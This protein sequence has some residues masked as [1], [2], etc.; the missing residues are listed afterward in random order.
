MASKTPDTVTER[1]LKRLF[2]ATVDNLTNCMKDGTATPKD[3]EVALKLIDQYQ[4]TIDLDTTKQTQ[5]TLDLPFDLE[6][7]QGIAQ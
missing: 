7:A 2:K 1:D 3:K 4:I 5:D 6:E